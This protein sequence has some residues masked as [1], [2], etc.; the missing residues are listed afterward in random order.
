MTRHRHSS[1]H[2]HPWEIP[3]RFRGGFPSVCYLILLAALL[4]ILGQL[5]HSKGNGQGVNAY[6]AEVSYI[7]DEVGRLKAGVDP[8]GDMAL[9]SYD[10][11]GNLVDIT[12]QSSGQVAIIQFLPDHGPEGIPVTIFGTGFSATPSQNTVSFNGTTATVI[13]ASATE[14]AT[15]VPAGATTGTLMITSPNG[16]DTSNQSFTVTANSGAPTITSINP[17]LAVPSTSITINGTNFDPTPGNTKVYFNVTR[18]IGASVSAT[19]ISTAIP[20]LATS[21]PVRI[22][23]LQ[24]MAIGPDLFI[25]PPTYTVNQVA[26]TGRI[27]LGGGSTNVAI[28]TQ[29]YIALMVFDGNGTAGQRVSVKVTAGGTSSLTLFNPNGTTLGITTTNASGVAFLDSQPLVYSGTYTLMMK[30]I[31][32]TPITNA[33]LTLYDVPLDTQASITPSGSSVQVSTTVPGQN[34]Q[35]TFTGTA[36]HRVSLNVTQAGLSQVSILNPD[37]TQLAYGT[38]S[39]FGKAFLEPQILG[40]SGFYRIL[41]D[42]IGT[43]VLTNATLSLYD[44]P[45]DITGSIVPG[46][47]PVQVTTTAPG[48]NASLTFSGTAGQR[49]S[50]NVTQGGLSQIRLNK[51][52]GSQ[53]ALTTTSGIGK[54]FL[55]T[56]VLPTTGT[57]AVLLDPLNDGL[58]SGATLTLYDVPSDITGSLTINVGGMAIPITTPGQNGVVTFSGTASLQVTVRV[59]GNSMSNVTV[60]LKRAN[61][62]TLTTWI[63]G[64]ASFNLPAQTLPATETYTILVDPYQTV[65]GTLTLTVTNP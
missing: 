44:V 38:T 52:D 37:G 28:G 24:G 46:G 51:P 49:V 17:T 21:G 31:N 18:D 55:D 34:A 29:N 11:V 4:G 50:L 58:V 13:S 36:V 53:L 20:S 65:T 16:S 43:N 23:T 56:Q 1:P 22:S 27:V 9:Y 63:S 62:T 59:T 5:G 14:V 8:A 57:Y 35:L 39:S 60:R 54:A 33:S 19:S 15:T 6:A 2:E 61:G 12:R 42:P 40:T 25:P 41:V 26:S 30:L 47:S 10:A 3:S 7:Y 48:Q 45:E 64:A 32:T